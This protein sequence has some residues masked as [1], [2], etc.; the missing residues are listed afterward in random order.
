MRPL[1]WRT[2]SHT[3]APEE[4]KLRSPV[5]PDILHRSRW[6]S[7]VLMAAGTCYLSPMKKNLN[8]QEPKPRKTIQ[9]VFPFKAEAVGTKLF[10]LRFVKL[11]VHKLDCEFDWQPT[12]QPQCWKPTLYIHANTH[13]WHHCRQSQWWRA[14]CVAQLPHRINTVL[15]YDHSP[16]LFQRKLLT[17]VIISLRQRCVCAAW[18]LSF[19]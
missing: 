5:I 16:G 2:Y 13:A 8:C 11:L 15:K 18:G 12:V 7:R 6:K 10:C 9:G 3:H 4:V 1:A 19:P 17:S 14:S